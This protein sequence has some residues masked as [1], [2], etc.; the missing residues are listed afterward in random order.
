MERS[1]PI[2]VVK[3]THGL[4]ACCAVAV[5]WDFLLHMKR[6]LNR[7]MSTLWIEMQ[8]SLE[9][10]Y[11]S[12]VSGA[13]LAT[14]MSSIPTGVGSLLSEV[15]LEPMHIGRDL[16]LYE[17]CDALVR[18]TSR[19]ACDVCRH[20]E[21]TCFGALA[22]DHYLRGLLCLQGY[23]E[24]VIREDSEAQLY[25]AR[26]EAIYHLVSFS[27]LAKLCGPFTL[28]GNDDV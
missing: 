11:A 7:W 6:E 25:A 5:F 17:L 10:E 8:A 24:F 12:Q 1:S 3:S 28:A 18:S 13:H 14:S 20:G 19:I 23:D 27:I 2:P 9:D 26:L 15:S 4:F 21:D 16:G 22:L